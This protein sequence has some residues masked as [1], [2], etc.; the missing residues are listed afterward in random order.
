MTN[1]PLVPLQDISAHK[2][3]SPLIRVVVILYFVLIFL[4]FSG[5]LYPVSDFW[6]HIATGR[7]ILENG[8]LPTEYLFSYISV[9][10]EA[11]RVQLVMR[12]FW[13]AQVCYYLTYQAFGDYGLIILKAATFTGIIYVVWLHLRRSL[14]PLSLALLLLIPT[15]LLS[16]QIVELRPQ[17]IS[18]LGVVITYFCLENW[19][20]AIDE[21]RRRSLI[22]LLPVPILLILW[23]NCHPGFVLGFVL[24]GAFWLEAVLTLLV[25]K[26][27]KPYDLAVISATFLLALLASL[28]NPNSYEAYQV[29]FSGLIF[30][31]SVTYNIGEYLPT[32]LYFK[33][34]GEMRLFSLGVVTLT[35][36][37]AVLASR[38]RHLTFR[39][40]FLFIGFLVAGMMSFRYFYL[41]ILVCTMITASYLNCIRAWW[42]RIPVA[43]PILVTFAVLTW[44]YTVP[45]RV[46]TDG[47]HAYGSADEAITF[48]TEHKLPTPIFHPYEWGG[49]ILWYIPGRYRTF[50][51][52]RA[53]SYDVAKEYQQVAE[54]KKS[55]VFA[56][57]GIK[58]VL[59]YLSPP[60]KTFITGLVF[61]L[62]KDP[63]WD[64][65]FAGANSVIFCQRDTNHALPTISKRF[66]IKRL[67]DV[68]KNQVDSNID[69]YNNLLSLAQLYYTSGNMSATEEYFLRARQIR[70]E[71]PFIGEWLKYLG[72]QK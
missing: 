21:Q 15:F 52:A 53:L 28:A 42:T 25:R 29:I 57:Y 7:W 6:W 44:H 14:L 50:Q 31:Q 3:E 12:G 39:H 69:V 10:P 27:R 41:S 26:E 46:V 47:P 70:P 51:D 49:N 32:W 66:Y 18:F 40:L 64:L 36:Y 30:D 22:F 8:R 19:Q 9:D 16:F 23:A 55:A 17:V 62:L 59:F 45:L 68:L 1:L 20:R 34:H 35:V 48:A 63:D 33:D 13:L 58:T 11:L 37:S 5:Q 67:T 38:Y 4:Y 65:V 2:G 72:R 54:G 61:S 24:V 60:G 56:K 71:D 43:L